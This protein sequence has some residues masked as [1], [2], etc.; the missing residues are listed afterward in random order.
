MK[1]SRKFL[2]ILA[3]ALLAACGGG[4]SGTYEGEA[5][6]L[7]F[8]GGKAD[9]KTAFSTIETDYSIDGDKIVLKAP[10]G[11]LVL[12]RNADGS[13]DTPWGPMKKKD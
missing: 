4:L 5:G 2:T 3:I 7:T 8:D 11:N 12:T 6:S 13:I 9:L 1:A 10:Q